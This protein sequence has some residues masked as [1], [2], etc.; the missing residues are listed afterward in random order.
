MMRG[1]G[2]ATFAATLLLIVGTINI[3]YG[4]GA[5]GNANIFHNG[6][7]FVFSDLNTMGWVLIV[8]GIVQLAGGLSLINGNTFGRIIAIVG[9]GLGALGAL[10][11]ISG[12]NPWWSLAVFFLCIYVIHGIFIYGDDTADVSR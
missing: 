10:F 6:Q 11:S 9:A 1:V 3:V 8:L 12:P 4:I 5:L 7:R 2:R